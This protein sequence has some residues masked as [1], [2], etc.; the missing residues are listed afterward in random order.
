MDTGTLIRSA[1]VFSAVVVVAKFADFIVGK[2]GR[3]W[4]KTQVVFRS[5][6]RLE[7]AS[8]ESA[9]R[10]GIE[11]YDRATVILFGEHALSFRSILT[12]I[13]MMATTVLAT[14]HAV[15]EPE[16]A[17]GTYVDLSPQ[18]EAMLISAA[19]VAVLGAF[20]V[21][22][23]IQR[24]SRLI[25]SKKNILSA[26]GGWLLSLAVSIGALKVVGE[27][28]VGIYSAMPPDEIPKTQTSLTSLQ[29]ILNV[30]FGQVLGPI[31]LLSLFLAAFAFLYSVELT[32]RF[33]CLLLARVDEDER[34]PIT[35]IASLFSGLV[36]IALNISKWIAAV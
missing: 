32:R 31:L 33:S 16:G 13:L 23:T 3:S 6:F 17:A 30:S 11:N 25:L 10:R 24:L 19:V 18:Q 15:P 26:F 36:L 12:F 4:F 5:W 1:V 14:S 8:L 35:L 7:S 27:I 34:S 28:I 29:T 2:K 22:A 20:L 9:L 21:Y